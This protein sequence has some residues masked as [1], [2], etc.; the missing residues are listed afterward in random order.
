MRWTRTFLTMGLIVGIAA[1]ATA[2]P[3][4][5]RPPRPILKPRPRVGA[6]PAPG[7]GTVVTI[8]TRWEG[9]ETTR[10]LRLTYR[11]RILVLYSPLGASVHTVFPGGPATRLRSVTTG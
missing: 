3:P 2:Q 8:G 5:P 4:G 9:Q 7:S 11:L 1:V 10:V 6:K